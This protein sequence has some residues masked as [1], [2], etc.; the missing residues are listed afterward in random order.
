MQGL[1]EEFNMY[2]K[3]ALRVDPYF[4]VLTS[5]L[6]KLNFNI[7]ISYLN[8]KQSKPELSQTRIATEVINVKQSIII[9][10]LLN[11]ISLINYLM[12]ATR[13]TVTHIRESRRF[14]SMYT[15]QGKT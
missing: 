7:K 8:F 3:P 14:E 9:N 1:W 15:L 13:Q 12:V 6:V 5:S 2:T 11:I 10:A 4:Q